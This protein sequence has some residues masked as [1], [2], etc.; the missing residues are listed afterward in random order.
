MSASAAVV[1]DLESYRQARRASAAAPA[2]A[3]RAAP[4]PMQA[5]PI[6][7]VLVWWVPVWPVA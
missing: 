3:R 1:V 2:R 5:P 4:A 6:V 7:P